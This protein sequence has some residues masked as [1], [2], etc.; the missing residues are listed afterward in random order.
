MTTEIVMVE[1]PARG[2]SRAALDWAVAV[3]EGLK[4]ALTPPNYG[5]GESLV[6]I[7]DTDPLYRPSTDW[8]QGG[9]LR[10]KYRVAVYEVDGGNVAATLRGESPTFWIDEGSSDA[11]ATG[12]TAL[13]AIC[14]AIVVSKLGDTVSVPACLVSLPGPGTSEG[15]PSVES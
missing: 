7:V 5:D 6:Y 8:S 12:R 15:R 11:D 2:L 3:A 13:I 14:R 1:V 9:P 10:D 4:P